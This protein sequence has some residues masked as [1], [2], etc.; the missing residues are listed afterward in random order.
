M[1]TPIKF[2]FDVAMSGRLGME[3]QPKDIQ[4]DEYEFAKKAITDYK[5]IRPIVQLGDLYRL[6]SPYDE[7][8]WASLMYVSKDKKQAA[9]FAY[10]L[11]YHGRTTYFET[12]LKGLNPAKNYKVTELNMRNGHASFYGNGKVFSGDYLMKAGISLNIGNP[13]D[14]TILLLTEQ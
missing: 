12:A 6:A 2:R 11:K 10:S 1:I 5:L 3:L 7:N 4:G 14:S 13:F 9:F 8:G